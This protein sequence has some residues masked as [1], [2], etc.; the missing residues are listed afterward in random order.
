MKKTKHIKIVNDMPLSKPAPAKPKKVSDEQIRRALE[1]GMS[2]TEIAKRYGV[3][4]TAISKRVKQ[5][6]LGTA[7]AAVAPLESMGF[8][9]KQ[10]RAIDRI[11]KYIGRA[12][13]MQDA[14]HEWLLDPED[15]S[16]YNVG[17]RATEIMVSYEYLE[18]TG[19]NTSRVVRRKESLQELLNRWVMKDDRGVETTVVES[20]IADPRE[21][22]L[23]TMAESRQQIGLAKDLVESLARVD[24]MLGL[25]EAVLNAVAEADPEMAH[26]VLDN[27]SRQFRLQGFLGEVGSLL[28]EE[29]E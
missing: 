13:Q 20:K 5:L 28:G 8:A 11:L 19:K 1:Q 27:L 21:L 16:R 22:L 14:C 7:A 24:M 12:E 26:R 17:P 6:N 2:K 10:V 29:G 23:K 9:R 3:T 15:P 25:K 18:P 4:P